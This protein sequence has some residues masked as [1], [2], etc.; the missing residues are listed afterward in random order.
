MTYGRSID[1]ALLDF[2]IDRRSVADS[3]R[4]TYIRLSPRIIMTTPTQATIAV[5]FTELSVKTGAMYTIDLH[6]QG[7]SQSKEVVTYLYKA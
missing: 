4:N 7:V 2:N 1:K 6:I 3:V 5:H